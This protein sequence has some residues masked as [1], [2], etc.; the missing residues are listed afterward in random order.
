[1]QYKKL[2]LCA[3]LIIALGLSELKAQEVIPGAGGIA[4]GAG[5]VVSY[6][7]GQLVYTTSAG[8]NGTVAT[9]VQQPYEISNVTGIDNDNR[10]ELLCSVYPNPTTDFLILIVE[11]EVHSEYTALL[12]TTNG[13]LIKTIPIEAS[14]TSIDMSKLVTSTYFL[15]IVHA[16]NASSSREIKTFKIIKN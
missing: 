11:S 6:S 8:T 10:I 5:G 7:V 4:A 12:Y 15:K 14:E 16:K 3:I 1:M 13:V 2:K 9:G